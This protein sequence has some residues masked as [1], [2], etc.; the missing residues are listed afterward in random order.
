MLKMHFLAC[1]SKIIIIGFIGVFTLGYQSVY[2]QND[3]LQINFNRPQNAIR[4]SPFYLLNRF[5]TL[6]FSYE[7]KLSN[8]F[9]IIIG[10]GAIMSVFEEDGNND[11]KNRR[12]GKFNL[13]FRHYFSPGKNGIYYLSLT[14]DYF[15]INFDR[16]RTFGYDCNASW[17]DCSYYQYREYAVQRRDYRFGF[18]GGVLTGVGKNDYID[19][20]IGATLSFQSFRTLNKLSGFDIQYGRTDLK[21]EGNRTLL[22]PI[23]VINIGYKFK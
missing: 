15:H 2:A 1:F 11:F 8:T 7:T 22:L 23:P 21:E 9:N 17:G 5:S 6:Q 3:S 10:A 19:I 4:L 12:G 18:K 20:G 13:E 16:G 14:T